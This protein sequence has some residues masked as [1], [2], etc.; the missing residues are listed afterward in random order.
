MYTET[1]T[2]LT[3]EDLGLDSAA[4]QKQPE[5]DIDAPRGIFLA[6]FL[7]SA[8]WALIGYLLFV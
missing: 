4:G 8:V 7:G 6:L 1:Q 3:F 5:S 2:G